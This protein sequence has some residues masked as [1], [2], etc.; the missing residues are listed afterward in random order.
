MACH[1]EFDPFGSTVFFFSGFNKVLFFS[2]F[3]FSGALTVG[4]VRFLRWHSFF[5]VS[6]RF[7][8]SFVFFCFLFFS[9]NIDSVLSICVISFGILI[10]KTENVLLYF[11][12]NYFLCG[13]IQKTT[14]NSIN[15]DSMLSICMIY[16]GILIVKTENVLLYFLTS[17]FWVAK[18]KNL[19]K[20][21][22][23]PKTRTKEVKRRSSSPLPLGHVLTILSF[24]QSRNIY[25][26]HK[27]NASF[28][29]TLTKILRFM[30]LTYISMS[31]AFQTFS[32]SCTYHKLR[33]H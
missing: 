20:K 5:L 3:S 9:I 12:T 27:I 10:V 29:G 1:L 15:I 33:R 11:L 13:K 31:Y 7:Y 23:Q 2:V 25:M 6:F 21:K 32:Q 14:K 19:Q 8:Q 4:S 26:I 16:F 24:W 30:W 18:Y 17:F 28:H 22:L